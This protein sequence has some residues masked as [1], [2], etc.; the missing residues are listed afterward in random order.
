MIA[1][2]PLLPETRP[3]FER[4]LHTEAADGAAYSFLTHTLWRDHFLF[5]WGLHRDCFLLFARYDRCIYMPLPPL[6][7]PDRQTVLDCFDRMDRENPDP[8]ISR[9][10]N[11][12]EAG[13]GFYRDAGLIVEPKDPEYLYRRAALAGLKG[14]RYK[15]QRA[16]CN[17]F[18][19]KY[20][21]TDRSYTSKD[22]PAARRLFEKWSA[23]RCATHSDP[24]YRF[25]IQD[26]RSVH[27]R[28]LLEAGRLGLVGRLVE[29]DG[30]IA[31]YTFGFPL[32]RETFCILLEVADREKSGAAA[33]L[34]RAFCRSL[35][36]FEWI[37]AMDDS[38]IP[39]LR[40]TKESYRPEKKLGLFLA[41][42]GPR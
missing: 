16:A 3:T 6:G 5:F 25:M 7:P 26:A 29:V 38:G 18:E 9:I 33:Y 28:A 27:H 19:K 30:E 1:L 4:F 24:V 11:I 8:V 36:E 32:N 42:R 22:E 17:R 10:E 13:A 14:D 23:D 21:P 35:A 41:R 37:N 40:Q 12:S 34:F 15:S 2:K 31:G 20:R 39:G